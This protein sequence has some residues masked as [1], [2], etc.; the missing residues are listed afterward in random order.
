MSSLQTAGRG[1]LAPSDGSP[2]SAKAVSSGVFVCGGEQKHVSQPR[3]ASSL[4]GAEPR[5]AGACTGS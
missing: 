5:G 2:G 3:L 1:S 4:A